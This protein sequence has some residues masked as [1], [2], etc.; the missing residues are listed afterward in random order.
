MARIRL[1]KWVVGCGLTDSRQ[2]AQA[3]IR[4]GQVWVDGHPVTKPGAQVEADAEVRIEGEGMPYVGR[5]GLKLEA[6]LDAFSVKVEGRICADLGASTG[7]F[8]DCLL[9]RGAA[10]VYAVDVGHGQLAP[11][12]REDAR[13]EVM[14]RTNVRHLKALPQAPDLIVGDLSFISL[15]KVLPAVSRLVAPGGHAILLIKPQFE[16]GKGKLG[17]GGVVRDPAARA[18]AISQVSAAAE[19]HGATVHGTI[20]SPVTGAKKG[21]VETLIFLSF[22]EAPTR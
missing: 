14:E 8:T 21:N 22:G 20:P 3:L 4:A 1:D 6:A 2:K 5:G 7:G 15:V 12:L 19:A 18:T 17:K 16:V 13:V 11:S 9:Q 10:R